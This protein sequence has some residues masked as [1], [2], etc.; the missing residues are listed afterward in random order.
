MKREPGARAIACNGFAIFPGCPRNCKR[1][2]CARTA[3]SAGPLEQT[4]PGRGATTEKPQARRPAI[5][6]QLQ[7]GHVSRGVLAGWASGQPM[8]WFVPCGG[9]SR[10]KSR[11][12]A[13]KPRD[14]LNPCA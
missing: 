6:T 3:Q 4:F 1:H 14:C 10:A 2:G 12:N 8:G 7:T 9:K 11:G 13:V 5:S